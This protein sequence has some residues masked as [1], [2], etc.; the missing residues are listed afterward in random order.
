MLT[1]HVILLASPCLASLKAFVLLPLCVRVRTQSLSVKSVHLLG[2]LLHIHQSLSPSSLFYRCL[3]LLLSSYISVPLIV[4]PDCT[5]MFKK[6]RSI[7][8]STHATYP[9]IPFDSSTSPPPPPPPPTLHPGASHMPLRESCVRLLTTTISRSR[10]FIPFSF[11][12]EGRKTAE[13]EYREPEEGRCYSRRMS[14]VLI[15][16]MMTRIRSWPQTGALSL[17]S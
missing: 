14:G 13:N 4:L 9:T 15:Y 6:P 11:C 16:C 17:P 10:V 5:P 2:C 8:Y 7:L 3:I 12:K 1:F